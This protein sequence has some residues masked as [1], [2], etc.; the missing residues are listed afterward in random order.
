[1]NYA[2]GTYG[3]GAVDT[4][5]SL[6]HDQHQTF[7]SQQAEVLAL[8]A[9]A[10]PRGITGHDVQRATGWGDSP[11][12]RAMSNL[13]QSGSLTRLTERRDN[14]YVHVLPQ[15][16]GDRETLPY[17]SLSEKHYLRGYTDG[18]DAGIASGLDGAFKAV[19]AS[20][21]LGEALIAIRRMIDLWEEPGYGDG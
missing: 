10:G 2:D 9:A 16:V 20:D 12:S 4:S 19:E 14:G 5:S 21:S 3:A 8:A 13:L 17:R 11:K 18:L 6:E 15:H 1:M 7:T